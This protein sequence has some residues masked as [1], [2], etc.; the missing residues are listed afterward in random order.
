MI[1]NIDEIILE[2]ENLLKNYYNLD[3]MSKKEI[4][5]SH[6]LKLVEE[7]WELS[8]WILK[9]FWYQRKEKLSRDNLKNLPLEFADVLIVTL[10]LA[11]S[12]NIDIDKA[13]EEKVEIIKKRLTK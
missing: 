7:V 5:Y 12:L 2:I 1:K 13:L 4:I 3:E 10:I 6:A 9:E 8:S 11:K